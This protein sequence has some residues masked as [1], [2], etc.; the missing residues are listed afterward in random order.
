[1]VFRV[2]HS[3]NAGDLITVLPGLQHLYRTKGIKTVFMQRLGLPAFYYNGA[4]HPTKEGDQQVCMNKT[5]WAMMQPLLNN[6]DYIEDAIEWQGQKVDIDFDIVRDRTFIPMPNGSIHH[7]PFFVFPELSCNPAEQWIKKCNTV[8]NGIIINFTERYRNPYLSYYFLKDYNNV[9]FTGTES[10]HADFCKSW[11]LDIPLINIKD[12]KELADT[13][14]GAKLFIG[15]QSFCWHLADAMKVNRILEVCT[16]FPN[17]FPTGANGAV[18]LYQEALEV[19][20][21]Q[22]YATEIS[23]LRY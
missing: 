16:A 15:N 3:F 5:M 18:V 4:T 22:K 2:K 9:R 10:E 14:A 12:F 6:Q 17:T 11:N 19:L 21:A 20:V 8:T 1:M 7:W 23:D 13:I